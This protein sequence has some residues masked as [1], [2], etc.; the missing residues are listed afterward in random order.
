MDFL[1]DTEVLISSIRQTL[2][3]PGSLGLLEQWA[4]EVEGFSSKVESF[5]WGGG[6]I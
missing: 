5:S 3:G 6:I 1:I 2:D 4:V